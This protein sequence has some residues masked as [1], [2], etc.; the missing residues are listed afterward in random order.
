MW[1]KRNK[2]VWHDDEANILVKQRKIS[3][4]GEKLGKIAK[5][6]NKERWKNKPC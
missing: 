3:Q 2:L 5:R 6:E 4:K 1:G